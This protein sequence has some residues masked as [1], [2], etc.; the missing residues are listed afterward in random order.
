[1]VIECFSG[2][3]RVSSSH[4]ICGSFPR[5]LCVASGH[6]CR[7]YELSHNW[8]GLKDLQFNMKNGSALIRVLMVLVVVIVLSLCAS[9]ASVASR[10]TTRE[11]KSK[12]TSITETATA[13]KRTA[14]DI[15][16]QCLARL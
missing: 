5:C 15:V 10:T 12:A 6:P 13:Q 9:A 3:I 8:L 7:V 11:S 16:A 1:M 2:C 4:T 14:V